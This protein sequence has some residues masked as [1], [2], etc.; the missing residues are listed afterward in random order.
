MVNIRAR[1]TDEHIKNIRKT[2]TDPFNLGK[3]PKQL[4]NFERWAQ[5]DDDEAPVRALKALSIENQKWIKERVKKNDFQSI[6]EDAEVA[7]LDPIALEAR[8]KEFGADSTIA[9][10]LLAMRILI[11]KYHQI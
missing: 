8:V 3:P 6:R 1:T 2:M 11:K 5:G 9:A 4:F 10:D 7:G